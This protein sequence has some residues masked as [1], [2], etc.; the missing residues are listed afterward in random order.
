MYRA[1]TDGERTNAAHVLGCVKFDHNI[2]D[3]F[4]PEISPDDFPD[5]NIPNTPEHDNF[6]DVNYAGR[7]DEWV[8]RWREFTGDGLANGLTSNADNKPPTPSLSVDGELPT[9][10]ADDNYVNA[11]FILPRGNALARGTV[12]GRKR[13]AQGNPIGNANTNP[14]LDSRVYHVKFEGG[15]MCELTANAIAESMYALCDADGNKYILFDSLLI[16]KVIGKP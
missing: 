11:S 8:K 6:N 4:G 13:D 2:Q 7:D 3:K 16:T 1:L 14:I 5:L 9:P 12:I 15:N 10:E